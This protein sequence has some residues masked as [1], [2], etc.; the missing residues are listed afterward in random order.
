[1]REG[2]K[3]LLKCDLMFVFKDIWVWF[4]V[5][6]GLQIWFYLF[7]NTV[8][9]AALLI[10]FV[11]GVCLL[12]TSV[13]DWQAQIRMYVSAGISRK[14]IFQVLLIRNTALLLTGLLIEAVMVFAFYPELGIKFLAVSGFYMLFVWGFGETAGVM[15]Y[16]RKKLG[17]FLTVIGYILTMIPCSFSFFSEGQADFWM[18]L[19]REIP[20]TAVFVMGALAAAV[21]AG[22]ICFARKHMGKYMVY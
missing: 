11:V 18:V 14:G 10:S 3:R 6:A 22:S 15:V 20:L 7:Y 8:A 13:K 17:M 21:L 16:Q 12:S 5:V 1:M 19:L 4:L 2:T 9:N